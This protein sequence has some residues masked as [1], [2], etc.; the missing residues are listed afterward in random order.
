MTTPIEHGDDEKRFDRQIALAREWDGLVAQVRE[1]DGFADFMRPP[2]IG[3]LLPAAA[4]GPVVLINVETT[5]CAAMILTADGVEVEPLPDLSADA[6][7]RTTTRYLRDLEAVDRAARAIRQAER[8]ST[9]GLRR[10]DPAVRDLEAALTTRERGLAETLAWLWDV[11]TG[12]VLDRVGFVRTPGPGDTWPRL[13]WCPTG[14][15]TLLPLHAAGYHADSDRGRTVIDR[16]I[17]SYTPTVRALV[18]A[19]RPYSAMPNGDLILVVAAGAVPG[20]AP[21]PEVDR[22]RDVLVSLFP[23]RHTL[24]QDDRATVA[25]VRAQLVTHRWAHFSCHG[26][27]TLD[28]PGRG[29]LVLS[30]GVLGIADISALRCQGEFAFLCACKTATGGLVLPD[31]AISLSAALHYTGYRHVIGTLWSVYDRTAA[32]VAEAVYREL[33]M[34]GV[35]QPQ[36]SAAALHHAVR[37]LRDDPELGSSAWTPFIHI[38]P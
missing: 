38:G 6:V 7:A 30:D 3:Q 32:D 12:P 27:Q 17:S 8:S 29:G 21:L 24:L 5:R 31:E 28:D 4:D 23:G 11:V 33:T 2:S 36:R 22:E 26:T 34:D 14:L 35:P 18:E 1:L 25:D 20:E 19:R 16:V 9:S 37:R 10:A 15:L 13:W